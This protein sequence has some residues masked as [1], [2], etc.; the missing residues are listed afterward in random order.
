VDTV[1]TASGVYFYKLTAQ[2]L[3]RRQPIFSE[4]RRMLIVK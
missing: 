2:P 4:T 1:S 3:D